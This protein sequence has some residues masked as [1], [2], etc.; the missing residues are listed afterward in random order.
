MD[1]HATHGHHGNRVEDF[2]LITGGGKYAADWNAPGQLYG[3]F[4]RADRAHAQIVSLDTARALAHPGVKHVFTG[5]DAVNAGYT[6]APHALTFPGLNGMQARAPERP[7][8]AH[9]KVR[10]VGEA[11][12]L[13]V[14]ESAAAARDAA[15]LVEVEYRELAPR[16]GPRRR[17]RRARR[18]C[19]T[20]CRATCR[21]NPRRATRRKSMPRSPRLRMSRASRSRSPA[22]RPVRWSRAR[23]SSPT[24]RK[25]RV[26]VQRMHAG[27][28]HFAYADFCVYRKCRRTS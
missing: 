3:H 17:W 2:R 11:L 15:E 21:S 28:D 5:I 14:A 25:G 16:S 23:A 18:N 27:R 9:G 19:T 4:V 10:F 26:L 22:L 7:V 20:T 1:T 12:A 8:L 13:V 6:K 24:T